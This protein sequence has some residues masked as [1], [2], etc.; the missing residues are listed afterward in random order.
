MARVGEFCGSNV[1]R[2]L[3][4]VFIAVGVAL[5][6]GAWAFYSHGRSVSIEHP[7]RSTGARH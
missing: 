7:T 4:G 3:L 1:T 2:F 5:A 6:V